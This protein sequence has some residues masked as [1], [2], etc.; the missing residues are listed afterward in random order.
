[1]KL[2]SRERV[3]KAL[4]HE[5]PDR[6]PFDCTFTIYAYNELIQFLELDLAPKTDC[7]LFS[8]VKVDVELIEAMQLDFAYI[9]LAPSSRCEPFRFGVEEYTDL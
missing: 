5:T 8:T 9:A 7:T 1:M 6:V 2:N 4:N 3:A